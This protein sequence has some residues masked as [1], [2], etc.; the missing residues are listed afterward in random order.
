MSREEVRDKFRQALSL[1]DGYNLMISPIYREYL[2][3]ERELMCT[4]WG[5]PTYNPRGWK[6]PCYLMTDAPRQLFKEFIDE[7]PWQNYGRGNDPRC[8][9]CMVHVGFEP[10]AVLGAKR[11]FG[12][13]WK[14]LKWQFSGKMGGPQGNGS[15]GQEWWRH[16]ERTRRCRPSAGTGLSGREPARSMTHLVTG[17]TGFLG[18]HVA[19]LLTERGESVRLLVRSSSPARLVEGWPAERAVG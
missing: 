8:E 11:K 13:N 5:N 19:R 18:S 7:T 14:L 2:K 6:G 10:S 16:G 4:A 12:D 17:A 9:D 1:I 15:R 3:G